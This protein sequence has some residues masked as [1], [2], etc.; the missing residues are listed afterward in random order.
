ML[1]VDFEAQSCSVVVGGLNHYSPVLLFYT[2]WR[3]QKTFRFSDVFR[4]YRK[5]TPGCNGLTENHACVLAI[6]QS[7]KTFFNLLDGTGVYDV[8]EYHK[9]CQKFKDSHKLICME[10]YFD[11]EECICLS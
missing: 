6:M 10:P 3:H 8:S 2:L 7:R 1:L 5:A 11:L 9:V 4:G